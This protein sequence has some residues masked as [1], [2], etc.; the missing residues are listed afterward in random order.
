MIA[1]A[2]RQGQIR[3]SATAALCRI[4]MESSAKTIWLISEKNA[5]T[6]PPLLRVPEGGARPA[7]GVRKVEAEA[8]AARTDPLAETGRANFDKRRAR[9]AARQAKIAALP[10]DAITGPSGGAAQIIEDA[11]SWMDKHLPRKADPELDTV[12]HPRSARASL[13]GLGFVHGFKWLMGY[14]L[15]NQALTTHRYWRSPLTRLATPSA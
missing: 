6:D 4:A 11:E 1:L 10:P 15:D 14:V 7:R 9:V 2:L 3:T 12:M 8:L 5:E 13:A